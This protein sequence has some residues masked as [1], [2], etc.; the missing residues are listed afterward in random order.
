MNVVKV[1][2][3]NHSGR[4]AQSADHLIID[5]LG[6]AF[7]WA[8][9]SLG[10]MRRNSYRNLLLGLVLA[11]SL[12]LELSGCERGSQVAA[13]PDT[14]AADEAAI[15]SQADAWFQAILAKDLEKTLSFYAEDAEYMSAGR[16]TATTPDQRRKLWVEDY[17]V[18]GFSSSE[19]TK[20][21]EVA[22]SGDLAYQNGTYVV[23]T[24]DRQG[25]RV[26]STGKFI[27]V[28]KKQSDGVW[29]AVVDIDN[30]DQ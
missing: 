13:T 25:H 18:P 5:T 3:H 19:V 8:R 24:L 22:R 6:S 21:I 10:N 14:R 17:A 7:Q 1:D 30:A 27:V 20:K 12:L 16:A 15:R 28:W 9:S 4:A 26:E 23:S 2:D 29:K 11:G